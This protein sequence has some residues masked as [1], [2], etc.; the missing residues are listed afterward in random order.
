MPTASGEAA[1]RHDI[2]G[3]AEGAKTED[4]DENRQRNRDAMIRVLFSFEK[5]RIITAVRQA[6][7]MASRNDALDG[8]TNIERL[9]EKGG[10]AHALGTEALL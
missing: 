5:S 4:A 2:D 1:Q 3:L 8:S 9:V 10:D 7:M 6:A